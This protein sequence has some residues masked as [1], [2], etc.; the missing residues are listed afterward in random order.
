M[1]KLTFVTII[2]IL[3]LGLTYSQAA[4]A[5]EVVPLTVS[6]VSSVYGTQ[7]YY[8]ASN[9]VDGQYNTYWLGA[10]DARP[11]WITF[12]AG[13][14]THIDDINVRWYSSSYAPYD[15]DIEVSQD[16]ATWEYVVTGAAGVFNQEGETKEIGRDARYV[17]LTVNDAR[18]Y[19]VVREFKA[20]ASLNVPHTIRFQ[21]VLG[22]ETGLP[23]DGT[24][25]LTFRLYNTET[26]GAVLWEETQT[27]IVI[28]SGMLDVELGSVV[29]LD[30]PFNEQYWLGAEVGIDG[31][32]SPRFKLT[33]VPYAFVSEE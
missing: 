22:D 28:E 4:A 20:F 13:A 21:G 5:D 17:R 6:D 1:K 7:S 3:L 10:R 26:A 9:A 14:V 32:M 29:D 15:Y 12:D 11:W 23:L 30:L 33:S 25:T 24:F 8:Q 31:E 2:S 18:Y 19:A 27:N 16:G